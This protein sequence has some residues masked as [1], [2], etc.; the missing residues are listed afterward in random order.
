MIPDK[1]FINLKILS[2]IQKNGRISRSSDG[3]ISLEHETF[4]QSIKRF[5]TSD[6]RRQSVFEINSII[7]ETIECMNN[8][9]NSKF[10]NKMYNTTDEYYKNCENLTL[11]LK[12]LLLGKGGIENLKFTYS[13]DHNV[14]SQLDILIIKIDSSIKD[15]EHKLSYFKSFLPDSFKQNITIPPPTPNYYINESKAVIQSLNSFTEQQYI[16]KQYQEKQ[17]QEK[18]YQE[19]QYQEQ[20][21]QEQQYPEQQQEQQQYLQQGEFPEEQYSE[22]QLFLNDCDELNHHIIEINNVDSL[23]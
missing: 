1:L 16:E 9:V 5:L 21:Y 22:Q 8:I 2:K 6:S 7:N 13:G 12:E 4:F 14:N 15:M 23:V 11:L 10:M 18:Q 17:Y 20:Q 19:Q 3:I